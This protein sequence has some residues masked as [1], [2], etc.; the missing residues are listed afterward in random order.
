MSWQPHRSSMLLP[1]HIQLA[2]VNSGSNERTST[3]GTEMVCVT[4]RRIRS[5]SSVS[6]PMNA[7]VGWPADPWQTGAEAWYGSTAMY[8][9][10]GPAPCTMK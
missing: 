7:T 4:R 3:A 10:R 6:A 1:L 2:Q 5:G 9:A 8:R